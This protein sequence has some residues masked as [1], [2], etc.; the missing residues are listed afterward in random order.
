MDRAYKRELGAEVDRRGDHLRY[1]I[2]R[3]GVRVLVGHLSH[4]WKGHLGDWEIS[5]LAKELGV[6]PADFKSFVAGDLN[7]EE[8]LSRSKPRRPVAHAKLSSPKKPDRHKKRR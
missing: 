1:Y 7:A 4:S 8:I 6:S 2:W 3:N 5:R